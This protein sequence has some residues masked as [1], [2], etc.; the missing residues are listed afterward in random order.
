MGNILHMETDQV[1]ELANN[2]R[3]VSQEIDQ[4]MQTASQAVNNMGWI[5]A[6]R[7]EYIGEISAISRNIS[8]TSENGR[9]LS[10]RLDAEVAEWEDVASSFFG[11]GGN[12][13][14]GYGGGGG[15][16]GGGSWGDIPEIP[17]NLVD[18]LEIIAGGAAL[19]P[20]LAGLAG[21]ADFLGDF[22][23]F[24]SGAN[25]GINM[26]N[27][28]NDPRYTTV[29]E[30]MSA[31]A[32]ELAF[33][34]VKEA[35]KE[36]VSTAASAAII[37]GLTAGAGPLGTVLGTVVAKVGGFLVGEVA[38]AAF[39]YIADSGLKDWCVSELIK[40]VSGST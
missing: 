28:W 23:D 22:G 6:A 36:G 29:E 4:Q 34:L 7:E 16:G 8:A 18:F 17:T 25:I 13:S 26:V 5:S 12:Q 24:L 37:G 33:G 35:I 9:I 30:K 38:G 27:A 20:G 11:E 10:D 2:L 39:D 14:G 21:L 31:V 40:V 1:R 32:V 19:Y 3:Q 15:G